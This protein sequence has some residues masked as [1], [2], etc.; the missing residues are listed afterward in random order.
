MPL[1][2][3]WA[4]N[5]V[6]HSWGYYLMAVAAIMHGAAIGFASSATTADRRR[7]HFKVIQGG[8]L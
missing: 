1:A 6:M 3:F 4:A 5:A 7:S 2:M 8:K